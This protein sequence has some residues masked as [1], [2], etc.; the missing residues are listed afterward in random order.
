M[1]AIFDLLGYLEMFTVVS[2]KILGK[3][4]ILVMNMDLDHFLKKVQ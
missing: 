1:C 2:I 4:P 3:F